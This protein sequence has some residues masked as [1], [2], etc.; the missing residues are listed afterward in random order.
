MSAF[1]RNYQQSKMQSSATPPGGQPLFQGMPSPYQPPALQPPTYPPLPNPAFLH[2]G[3]HI[4]TNSLAAALPHTAFDPREGNA[5]TDDFDSILLDITNDS[6]RI[7]AAPPPAPLYE[8]SRQQTLQLPSWMGVPPSSGQLFLPATFTPGHFPELRDR[9][10]PICR[11]VGAEWECQWSDGTDAPAN[12]FGAD[13][14]GLRHPDL[15]ILSKHFRSAHA[16]FQDATPA[17]YWLC[18]ACKLSWTESLPVC[19]QCLYSGRPTFEKWFFGQVTAPLTWTTSASS[20][21]LSSQATSPMI[22]SS[23]LSPNSR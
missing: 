17:F 4:T 10:L 5:T 15:L 2:I 14:C 11:Y 21:L 9:R 13:V 23:G 3:G 8:P 6:A 12:V 1:E 16:A 22:E 19:P 20:A 7:I 18:T